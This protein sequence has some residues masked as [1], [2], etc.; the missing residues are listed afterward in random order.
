M[1]NPVLPFQDLTKTTLLCCTSLAINGTS[2]LHSLCS[3]F[4]SSVDCPADVG[5]VMSAHVGINNAGVGRS[6]LAWQLHLP[7]E[8]GI[9]DQVKSTNLF[10]TEWGP[11]TTARSPPTPYPR[12][13][14]T[15]DGGRS[16][17]I[18]V[19]GAQEEINGGRVKTR[20]QWADLL[21]SLRD[22]EDHLPTKIYRTVDFQH[23]FLNKRIIDPSLTFLENRP[24]L[25]SL[26][27]CFLITWDFGMRKFSRKYLF[28][29]K[30]SRKYV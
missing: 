30:F 20:D 10:L 5:V 15:R 1:T 26:R 18:S 9:G 27:T 6:C 11:V 4:I 17:S 23:C 25:P 28:S 7:V 2:T 3:T 16:S 8:Q 14:V 24:K 21:W 12:A 29:Q 13:E 22:K 19:E